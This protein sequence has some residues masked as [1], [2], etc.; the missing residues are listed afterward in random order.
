MMKIW[1]KHKNIRQECERKYIRGY[2]VENPDD[3]KSIYVRKS[4]NIK[5]IRTFGKV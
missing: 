4:W 5:E 3:N 2:N 1:M